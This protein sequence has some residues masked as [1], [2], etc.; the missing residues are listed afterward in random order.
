MDFSYAT[1]TSE[2]DWGAWITRNV[3][4]RDDGIG[5]ATTVAMDRSA[6]G[7]DAVDVAV[8]DE[9]TLYT[10]RP[11]G[12]LYRYDPTTDLT[13]RVW[14]RGDGRIEE[15]RAICVGDDRVFVADGADGDVAV[16]SPRLQRPIGRLE[17]D[18]TDPVELVHADG[19]CYVL[20]DDRIRL[21][22]RGDEPEL[23][24]DW[25]VVDPVDLAV[26][27][28][29]R[30]YVLDR[31]G[32]DPIVRSFVGSETLDDGPFPITAD[33]FVADGTA[34]S[35][36]ALATVAGTLVVAGRTDDEDAALFEWDADAGA[37]RERHALERPARTLLARPVD[38]DGR[39]EFYALSDPADA[40]REPDGDEHANGDA[41]GRRCHAL[42]EVRR[43]A[44]HPRRDRHV[45]EAFHR[46]DSG[47]DGTAWHRLVPRIG[48]SSAST[49]VRV[50]YLATDRRTPT[51]AGLETVDGVSAEAAAALRE[52][53]VTSP[54]E[55]ADCDVDRLA[56]RIDDPAVDR[57]RVRGWRAAAIDALSTH[58]EREW[59]T[60]DALDPTDVLLRGADGR[61]LYVQLE[62]DGTPR[63]SPLI[64]SLRAFCPRQSYLRYLPELFREDDRSAAF[65]ERY[66]SVFESVFTDIEAEIEGITRYF[67]PEGVPSESLAWLES[68][69]AVETDDEWPESARREL[70]ARAPELYEL[71]GTKAGM[72]AML[73]LYL[74]HAADELPAAFDDGGPDES[75]GRPGP[76]ARSGPA[77]TADGGDDFADDT[78]SGHRLFFIDDGDLARIDRDAARRQFPPSSSGASSVAVFCGPFEADEQRDA[79]ERIVT[80]DAP[81]HVSADVIELDDEWTL[82]G[83]SFLG[84]NC[85]LAPREFA[86][87]DATLGEDTVLTARDR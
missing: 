82:E 1:T 48:R 83:D 7:A 31:N 3:E 72:R 69:L 49:Q 16:V 11:S 14:K 61:Y 25:W 73:E 60:V 4:V 50:R 58:A 63:S 17:T 84:I 41:I 5:L 26:T 32:G 35:P 42:R 81:V 37:F 20:D 47:T 79:I 55:L 46:Y 66:L 52:A 36:T 54:W 24:I 39:W 27:A 70:L 75:D 30:G 10:L 80:A 13:Q 64:D 43:N 76:T 59:T 9:G 12:S 45:G 22:G 86:V 65:L 23:S 68:W 74:R 21:V 53:D 28:D 78:P 77:A 44:R 40:D 8:D 87:G 19:V 51:D 67:D 57:A 56:D 29:G 2:A 85:R 15:P 18:A 34:F 62:L 6:L 71:R 33:A 38:A